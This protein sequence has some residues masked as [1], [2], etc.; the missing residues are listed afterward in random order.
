[1]KSIEVIYYDSMV[2]GIKVL[3]QNNRYKDI[4]QVERALQKDS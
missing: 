3:L 2:E 1:M 4:L